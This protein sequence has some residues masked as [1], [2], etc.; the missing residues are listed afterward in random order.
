[1]NLDIRPLTKDGIDDYLFFFDNFVF[2]ENPDR[3]R[4]YCCDYHFLGDIE[5]CT[6]EVSR[7]FVIN[8]IEENKF[9]GYLAFENDRPIGWCNANNR[10]NYQ[11][12]LRDIDLVDDPDDEVF[13]IVCF[14]IDP[15]H[16]RQGIAQQFVQRIIADHSN[17]SYDHV[18]AYPRKGEL[19]SEGNFNGPLELYRRLDFMI[20]KEHDGYYVMRKRLK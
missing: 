4:C 14:L 10:S 18:E 20:H 15:E 9:A 19:S 6:R 16:R 7:P 13:S 8:L 5:T 1:M 12:L 2:Q 17:K 3:S 11:R